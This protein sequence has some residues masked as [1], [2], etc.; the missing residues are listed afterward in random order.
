MKHFEQRDP[1][2]NFHINNICG[3]KDG[4]R[5]HIHVLHDDS[6]WVYTNDVLHTINT[7][8]FN[9]DY[10]FIGWEVEDLTDKEYFKRKLA[11]KLFDNVY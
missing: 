3:W 4:I 11:G 8:V 10:E 6:P 7:E 9:T 2:C 1:N 5:D